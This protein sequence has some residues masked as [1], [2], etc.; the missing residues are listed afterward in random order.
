MPDSEILPALAE[1]EIDRSRNRP[2]GNALC[3]LTLDIHVQVTA[4]LVTM[5]QRAF[6]GE[7]SLEL[8]SVYVSLTYDPLD[9]T[10]LMAR[11]KSPKAGAVVLFAGTLGIAT[12]VTR[13]YQAKYYHFSDRLHAGLFRF[14]DCYSSI[15]LD[16]CA[17][18]VE[19]VTEHSEGCA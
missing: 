5:D 14:Q 12:R 18:S 8:S 10:A 17:I 11:V 16:L 2:H 1:I 3:D 7:Q 4:H 9:A 13:I 6:E 19:V 15:I